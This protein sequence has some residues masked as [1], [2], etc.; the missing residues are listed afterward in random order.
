MINDLIKNRYW[1]LYQENDVK[2]SEFVRFLDD[3]TISGYRNTNERFWSVID[4]KLVFF[5]KNQRYFS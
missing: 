1:N 2:M 3:G 5:V 4:N